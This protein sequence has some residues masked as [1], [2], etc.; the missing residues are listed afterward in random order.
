MPHSLHHL[1]LVLVLRLGQKIGKNKIKFR[2]KK[3]RVYFGEV[4]ADLMERFGKRVGVA[5]F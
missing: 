1:L 3:K 2:E 4:M 5:D